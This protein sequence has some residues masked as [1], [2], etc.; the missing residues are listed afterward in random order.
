MAVKGSATYQKLKKEKDDEEKRKRQSES[1]A[2]SSSSNT[3]TSSPSGY[4]GTK[5]N[6][7]ATHKPYSSVP[8]AYRQTYQ[9]YLL[10]KQSSEKRYNTQQEALKT[11]ANVKSEEWYA[12]EKA[13]NRLL[14]Y[15]DY[16]DY[17]TTEVY[18]TERRRIQ[19]KNGGSSSSCFV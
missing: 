3:S 19:R 2:K 6:I 16:S 5:W 14:E 12:R 4:A 17:L 1:S 7:G 15:K 9:Q 11:G 18:P 10:E 13:A 8:K